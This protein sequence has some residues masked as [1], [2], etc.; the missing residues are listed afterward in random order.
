[1]LE[2]LDDPAAAL[3]NVR[4]LLAPGCRVIITVPSGPM[5][6]FDKHIGHRGHFTAERLAETLRK[7]GL[8]VADLRGA[9]FPFFNV[10]R[11]V[12][13]AR[14]QKLIDDAA[15]P[16]GDSLPLAA[17]A[18]IRLFSWLF[19]MNQSKGQRGWQLVAVAVEPTPRS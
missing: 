14:G 18:M 16:N 7:A 5:S 4:P 11:M 10:Y 8:E 3:A 2:H 13:I 9:G 12:V 6:A 19:R 17:R 15:S 1:V